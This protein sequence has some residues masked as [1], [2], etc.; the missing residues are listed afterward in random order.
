MGDSKYFYQNEVDKAFFHHYKT[1]GD[2]KDFDRRTVSKKVLHDKEI[3]I[4]KGTKYYLT[5]HLSW[6]VILM[7]RLTFRIN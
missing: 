3:N 1:Y 6:L 7:M 4:A 5:L 2:F